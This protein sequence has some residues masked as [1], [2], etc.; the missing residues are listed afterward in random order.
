MH[1]G[2]GNQ[3]DF[4]LIDDTAEIL[5]EASVEDFTEMVQVETLF[6][7]RGGYP[8]PG[9][10]TLPD[11]L[12]PRGAID[13]VVNLA[14]EDRFEILLHL[15]SSDFYQDAKIHITLFFDFLEFRSNELDLAVLDIIHFSHVEIFEGTALLAPELDTHICLADDFALEC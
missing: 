1:I 4:H 14:L 8:D 3:C 9:D 7:S 5:V 6:G 2:V 11:V 10:I 12:Y 15:P 13:E